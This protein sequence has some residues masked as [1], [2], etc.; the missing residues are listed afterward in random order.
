[1]LCRNTK[2]NVCA[3]VDFMC[4][5]FGNHSIPYIA[6]VLLPISPN[7]FWGQTNEE[8]NTCVLCVEYLICDTKSKWA[9]EW[10]NSCMRGESLIVHR[11][12][13]LT[14]QGNNNGCRANNDAVHWTPHKKIPWCLHLLFLGSVSKFKFVRVCGAVT[15]CSEV[16]LEAAMCIWRSRWQLIAWY[17]RD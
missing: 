10:I 3:Y 13:C 7:K 15:C 5:Y 16:I 4:F 6:V 8:K 17:Q 9:A 1:M 12:Y 2:F 14:K 11:S